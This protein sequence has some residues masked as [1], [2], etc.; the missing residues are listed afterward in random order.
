MR[1]SVRSSGGAV[2]GAEDEAQL[3]VPLAVS[4]S[5]SLLPAPRC[6]ET[7]GSFE[8]ILHYLVSQVEKRS[9]VR[10]SID[11]STGT[12]ARA[13]S[14]SEAHRCDVDNVLA[15]TFDQGK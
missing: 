10:P 5:K 1:L 12:C 15:A 2:R 14:L 6:N 13:R 4:A 9:K 7:V 8:G 3:P 11:N